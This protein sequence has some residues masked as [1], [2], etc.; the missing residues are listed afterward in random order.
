[1]QVNLERLVSH[2]G[3]QSWRWKMFRMSI[4]VPRWVSVE[5]MPVLL[6]VMAWRAY[7]LAAEAAA[8]ETHQ[9]LELEE[10]RLMQRKM[11]LAMKTKLQVAEAEEQIYLDYEN[12]KLG[13][14]FPVK[15]EDET[16]LYPTECANQPVHTST[17][18]SLTREVAKKLFSN[19]LWLLADIVQKPI[20]SSASCSIPEPGLMK[21]HQFFRRYIRTDR[22]TDRQ[23]ENICLR[24]H[25][26]RRHNNETPIICHVCLNHIKFETGHIESPPPL[27]LLNTTALETS[28]HFNPESNHLPVFS[29]GWAWSHS[30]KWRLAFFFVQNICENVWF[31]R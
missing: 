7:Y 16:L 22:E 28:F 31:H 5:A 6:R 4:L 8:I 25:S 17:P 30:M 26:G 13:V 20:R 3:C 15:A 27:E 2:I 14:G 10:F 11:R 24:H 29:R 21:A 9:K 23:P 1:M 12:K 19:F 18:I